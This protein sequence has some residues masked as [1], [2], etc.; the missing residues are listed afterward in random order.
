M[1]ILEYFHCGHLAA[2]PNIPIVEKSFMRF[3]EA[4]FQMSWSRNES[5]E[6]K[7]KEGHELRRLHQHVL[8]ILKIHF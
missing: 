6:E 5:D 1:I 3:N 2:L 4:K 8:N 7:I